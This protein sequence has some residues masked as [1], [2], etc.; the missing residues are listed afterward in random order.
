MFLNTS[1]LK[2]N[3]ACG[4][5]FHTRELSLMMI[6]LYHDC[7]RFRETFAQLC[8]LLRSVYDN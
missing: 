6:I 8:N 7:F 4:K 1:T 5:R 3:A 2:R